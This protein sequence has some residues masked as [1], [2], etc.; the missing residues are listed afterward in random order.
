MIRPAA[1]LR[2]FMLV[3]IIGV[4]ALGL[5]LAGILGKLVIDAIYLQRIAAEH[6]NRVA[7]MDSLTRSLRR[8]AL[9]AVAYEWDASR[10]N[11]RTV[12]GDGPA[13]VV[14]TLEPEGVQRILGSREDRVWRSLRLRFAWG[15]E[16]GPRGDVL[17]LD[18]IET[19]PA[20]AA[21]LPG[22]TYTV[23]FGLPASAA[24]P[25]AGGEEL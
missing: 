1:R 18:L 21:A 19:P 7:V 24:Q 25:G 16:Q 11:L 2:G 9:A 23:P 14:Y 3:E 6:A 5:A 4:L 15:R 10:L 17:L 12:T 13:D 22:R 20:R 8:D